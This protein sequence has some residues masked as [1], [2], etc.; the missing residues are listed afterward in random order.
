MH[1]LLRRFALLSVSVL[2]GLAFLPATA[3]PAA[4][5]STLLCTGYTGCSRAGMGSAGYQS[6]SGSMYWRMYSG[7]NCT[8]YAA[9]RMVASGLPNERPW[10]GGGNATYWGTSNAELTN[11]TPR[12][13]SVAWWKAY[14]S[15]AG[16]AG[17][18]AYVEQVISKDEIIV[19]QD[20]WGG[21]FSWA[22]IT[23]TS[24]N[25]PS[26]FVHFNDVRMTN[27]VAPTVAG[28][29]KVGE[30]LAASL[31]TWS[32]TPTAYLY[33]WRA[34]GVDLAG[35]TNA[36]FVPSLAEQGKQISVAVTGKHVGYR[37]VSVV[38]APTAAVTSAALTSTAAPVITGEPK[39]GSDLVASTGTWSP[40]PKSFG[41]QWTA[42]GTAVPGATSRTFTPSA[43]LVGTTLA[44]LVTA[45]KPGYADV[46]VETTAPAPVSPGELEVTGDPEIDGVAQ[47]GERLAL[48]P[49]TYAPGDAALTVQWL[50]AGV[51]VPGA[52]GTS[53]QLTAADV[54]SR[55]RA[56]MT[57]DRAGYEQL[58]AR[59]APT[60]YVRALPT[61]TVLGTGG[62]DKATFD[63]SVVARAVDQVT[64]TIRIRADGDL[65]AEVPVTDGAAHVIV[66]DL[67]E[68]RHSFRVRFLGSTS[69]AGAVTRRAV[70]IL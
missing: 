8:N 66:R 40:A 57:L 32:P 5:S 30:I 11:G 43:D 64:G 13:G 19:S 7:H 28:T 52:T 17:H 45:R 50:R 27:T 68:G 3:S 51:P 12:V 47:L 62:N 42:D 1:H 48:T 24:G 29:P 22:R 61:M 54:G 46:T 2:V 10:S 23:R 41:Y 16:S 35:A 37:R 67:T 6:A 69:V 56:R 60:A 49:A 58:T 21:D 25:W 14:A 34:D 70:N 53:Y 44:V 63:V 18:V 33:Q 39:V 36:T 31:G 20:S 59:T 26:G 4:A 15:P 65:L 38:S 55:I 9:Y